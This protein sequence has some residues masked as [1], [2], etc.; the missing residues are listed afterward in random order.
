MKTTLNTMIEEQS[1]LAGK[2]A[3]L[4]AQQKKIRAD[5]AADPVNRAATLAPRAGDIGEQITAFTAKLSEVAAKIEAEAAR[6]NSPAVQ[7]GLKRA[8]KIIADGQKIHGETVTE[9]A[10]MIARIDAAIAD[11]HEAAALLKT[12]DRDFLPYSGLYTELYQ[13]RQTV[14]AWTFAR[15]ERANITAGFKQAEAAKQAREAA[16]AKEAAQAK[17]QADAARAKEAARH[18]QDKTDERKQWFMIGTA[19][20]PK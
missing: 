17:A 9:L 5:M 16:K 2:I 10:A 13:L 19:F 11:S 15:S 7:K 3:E 8:E 18:K 6:L 12:A 1:M 20:D 14:G 4:E